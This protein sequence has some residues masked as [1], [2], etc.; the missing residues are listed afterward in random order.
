[1]LGVMVLLMMACRKH[2]ITDLRP[3]LKHNRNNWKE[4]QTDSPKLKQ[5][6]ISANWLRKIIQRET[7]CTLYLQIFVL[8]FNF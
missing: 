8:V 4:T 1:M 6:Q 5:E 7:S 2:K 3:V